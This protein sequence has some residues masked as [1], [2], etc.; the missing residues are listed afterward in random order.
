M[1]PP[2]ANIPVNPDWQTLPNVITFTQTFTGPQG[3]PRAPTG[4]GE[5]VCNEKNRHTQNLFLH[6]ALFH[7]R[8]C[9]RAANHWAQAQLEFTKQACQ[10]RV[11]RWTPALILG[12]R[13]EVLDKPKKREK[14][15]AFIF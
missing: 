2:P 5:P 7:G 10:L 1:D 6:K 9:S 15:Q 11:K 3:P 14:T 13:K 4:P 8:L 12:R